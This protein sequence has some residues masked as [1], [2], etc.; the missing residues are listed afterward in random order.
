MVLNLDSGTL[1]DGDADEMVRTITDVIKSRR[2]RPDVRL[3]RA[4]E[5]ETALKQAAKGHSAVLV[6]GGDGTISTAA[7]VFAGK[8]TTLGILPLGTMNLFARALGIPLALDQAVEMLVGGARQP[9]DVGE[10]NG[11]IFVHHVTLGLHPRIVAGRE[12]QDYRSRLGK[13]LAGIK[14]WWKLVRRAPRLRLVLTID[15]ERLKLKTASLVIAN[16]PFVEGMGG[17]PHSEVPDQG[18]LALYIARTRDWRELLAM[19]AQASLGKWESNSKLDFL[20]GKAISIAAER[21]RLRVSIDGELDYL[22]TPLRAKI[23]PNALC[24]LCP[25]SAA[26]KRRK[27]SAQPGRKRRPHHA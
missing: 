27:D 8:K 24:V 4:R 10:V 25:G 15:K 14:I 18:K 19:S 6:G 3:V 22:P 12:K 1:R 9:I 16:N 7:A 23:I 13:T 5:I 2:H 21:K 17:L 20:E 11:R 26:P